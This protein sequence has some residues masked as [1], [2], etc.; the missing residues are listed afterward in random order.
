MNDTT[1]AYTINH[2][3]SLKEKLSNDG[4]YFRESAKFFRNACMTSSG[5]IE[6]FDMLYNAAAGVMDSK[7]YQFAM[8]PRSTTNPKLLKFPAKLR[9]HNII[10]PLVELFIGEFIL[11]DTEPSVIAT[12]ED[13]MNRYQA[14]LRDNIMGIM[15]QDFIN[16][17]NQAGFDTNV[18][19]EN[20]PGYTEFIEDFPKTYKDVRTIR[21]GAAVQYLRQAFLEEKMILAFYDWIVTGSVTTLKMVINDELFF[22]VL[23]PR[24]TTV[25]GNNL[26]ETF[27]SAEA[28]S[29]KLR[30]TVSQL[31]EFLALSKDELK[32]LYSE[33]GNQSTSDYG[34]T[35]TISVLS[36]SGGETTKKFDAQNSLQHDVFFETWRGKE[37]FGVLSYQDEDLEGV[38][39]MEVDE[40][41]EFS[42]ELGDIEI[43]WEYRDA[44]YYCFTLPDDSIKYGKIFDTNRLPVNGMFY[45]FRSGAIRSIVKSGLDYQ[46]MVNL[47][48]YRAEFITAVYKG[49][50]I[51]FP[52]GLIPTK[53]GWGE[54]EFFYYGDVTRILL[55]DESKEGAATALSGMKSFDLP[56]GS[57]LQELRRLMVEIREDYW[58]EVGM[59][60]QRFG[61]T[62]VSEGKGV[63]EQA[64][65]RSAVITTLLFT[66]FDKF[67]ETE[68]NECI[69]LLRKAWKK[70]K[71]SLLV[72]SDI[73]RVI[74][75]I[76]DANHDL[77]DVG[78]FIKKSQKEKE[79]I[80]SAY[81]LLLSFSQNG[82]DAGSAIK[83]LNAN[84]INKM[85][86]IAAKAIAAE[87]RFQ[88]NL[89][90][91]R[92]DA[93]KEKRGALKDKVEAESA[94][95]K[96]AADMAYLATV[97]SA[98][99]K[100]GD[101]LTYFLE[102][103]LK[104]LSEVSD[105]LNAIGSDS[106][107]AA[108]SAQSLEMFRQEL[109]A[110]YKK[111]ETEMLKA[112]TA[113]KIA[114]E[115]RNRFDK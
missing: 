89:E 36:T 25:Y 83:M 101:E 8:N 29:V 32:A 7:N 21:A 75:D 19:T 102:D 69:P 93:E 14:S 13:A 64:R 77:A 61:D 40:T 113:L 111:S 24:L 87:R 96:Y 66:R 53:E 60:R 48:A 1:N 50:M 31:N 84:S 55:F 98:K 76:Q 16:S 18:P 38:L 92:L 107:E 22:T 72:N 94:T 47:L 5:H 3:A 23:D 106:E 74:L 39:T 30:L 51:T 80:K 114:E 6:D 63:S 79:K 57:Y 112:A 17:L 78:V 68:Y 105:N 11:G 65:I 115:N 97:E 35:P 49:P 20:I 26:E 52:K 90:Q 43:K 41:Y 33:K 85:Q 62:Y 45:G 42:P 110:K 54:E 58:D 59:N 104:K 81:E 67:L 70:G 10:T 28:A 46:V 73:D 2:L 109:A 37:K 99:I 100:A 12:D 56:L 86:D 95:K 88:E 9:N 44:I 27:S 103:T 82:L 108:R 34:L 15:A 71:K 4:E 91:M